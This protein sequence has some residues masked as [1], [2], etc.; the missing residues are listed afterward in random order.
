MHLNINYRMN[1]SKLFTMIDNSFRFVH[2][3]Y[4]LKHLNKQVLLP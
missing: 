4:Y 1:T 3:V 2:L